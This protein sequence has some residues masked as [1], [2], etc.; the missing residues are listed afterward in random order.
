MIASFQTAEAADHPMIARKK[1]FKVETSAILQHC[2]KLTALSA[3]PLSALNPSSRIHCSSPPISSLCNSRLSFFLI[4]TLLFSS[5]RTYSCKLLY[6]LLRSSIFFSLR[7]GL[8]KMYFATF[9]PSLLAVISLVSRAQTQST[10]LGF[11]Y[12]KVANASVPD[13]SNIT[14]HTNDSII[15]E[16]TKFAHTTAI[17][18]SLACYDTLQHAL[19]NTTADS[20]LYPDGACKCVFRMQMFS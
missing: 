10:A 12:P 14:V 18:I 1:Q 11:I 7:L 16:Y 8:P 4:L 19:G 15:V 5:S 17:G 9:L 2:H 20:G 13:V 3:C 6:H